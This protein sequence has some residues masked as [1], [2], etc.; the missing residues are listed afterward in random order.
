M[1]IY[2]YET[3]P[4]HPGETVERFE[5]KQSMKEP[6]LT[7]HPETG[8]PIRRVITGGYGMMRTGEGGSTS[9]FSGG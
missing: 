2:I 4:R 9:E 7:E 5:I 1:A 3:V 8:V 6:A